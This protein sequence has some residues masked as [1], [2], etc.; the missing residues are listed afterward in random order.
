MYICRF[1]LTRGWVFFNEFF[2]LTLNVNHVRR[3]FPQLSARN[4]KERGRFTVR[5]LCTFVR[6][7]NAIFFP[8]QIRTRHRYPPY[9]NWRHPLFFF[10]N[11][12]VM[13]NYQQSKHCIT[14]IC[15]YMQLETVNYL[16]TAHSCRRILFRLA[17][18]GNMCSY[19]PRIANNQRYS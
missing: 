17:E 9:L 16:W 2:P 5:T 18:Y 15:P 1:W 6:D 8:I 7:N 19:V 3:T 12:S 13:Q 10:Q 14:G 11:V 4:C